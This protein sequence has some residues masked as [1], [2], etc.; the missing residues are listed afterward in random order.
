[1]TKKRQYYEPVTIV[2]AVDV[3]MTIYRLCY[4]LFSRKFKI[5]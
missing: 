5:R 1:M 2:N 4:M 3:A